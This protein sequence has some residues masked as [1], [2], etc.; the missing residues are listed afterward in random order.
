MRRLL[1][2][3]VLGLGFAIATAAEYNPVRTHPISIGPEASRIIVG[4]RATAS[5]AVVRTFKPRAQA[6]SVK[7]VQG[8]R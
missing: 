1:L 6:Q 5:N 2:F 8:A 7:I 4:F 3:S